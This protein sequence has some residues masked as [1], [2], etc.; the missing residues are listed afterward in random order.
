MCNFENHDCVVCLHLNMLDK[1]SAPCEAASPTCF[2]KA[3]IVQRPA[4]HLS[5]QCRNRLQHSL[6]GNGSTEPSAYR[7]RRKRRISGLNHTR[8]VDSENLPPKNKKRRTFP[9]SGKKGFKKSKKRKHQHSTDDLY[10]PPIK[11]RRVFPPKK[12]IFR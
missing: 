11:L 8:S 10:Q 12:N 1:F 2:C 9:V 6:N 4:P 3:I 7:T 5:R